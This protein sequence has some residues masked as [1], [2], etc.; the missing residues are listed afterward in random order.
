MTTIQ[1]RQKTKR[2]RTS[3]PAA[4]TGAVLEAA[5]LL[6]D[7]IKADSILIVAHSK[8]DREWLAGASD[9]YSVVLAVES[10]RWANS[11]GSKNRRA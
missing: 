8:V 10:K 5:R 6:A 9:G 1:E 3:R 4:T 11:P 2:S 7:T